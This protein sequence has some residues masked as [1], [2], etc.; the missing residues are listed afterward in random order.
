M[1]DI[2][3]NR[4]NTMNFINWRTFSLE[5]IERKFFI[6]KKW[7]NQIYWFKSKNFLGTFAQWIL[8]GEWSIRFLIDNNKI[9]LSAIL[10]TKN[11]Y[12]TRK[13]KKMSL[14]ISDPIGSDDWASR[15]NMNRICGFCYIFWK[16]PY[17]KA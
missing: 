4:E 10:P 16:N 11:M 15:T 17:N 3:K 6:M 9:D 8:N 12:N 2:R 7:I 1:Y 13:S 5:N 14:W